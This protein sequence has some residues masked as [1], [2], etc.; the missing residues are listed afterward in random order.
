MESITIKVD[1]KMARELQKAMEPL[2]ATKT[3]FIR[4]AIR[5]KIKEMERKRF[6]ED[7]R[8]N[9]GKSPVKTPLWMDEVIR[10]RASKKYFEKYRDK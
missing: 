4:E 10:E 8:K 2:Y 1:E 5:D 3:E 7:L 6:E 9:F